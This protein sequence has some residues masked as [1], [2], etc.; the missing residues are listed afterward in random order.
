MSYIIGANGSTTGLQS[1]GNMSFSI[2]SNLKS[3]DVDRDADTFTLSSVSG[4]YEERFD[5]EN[6]T[7]GP[8]AEDIQSATGTFTGV[9]H[10]GAITY[11][12]GNDNVADDIFVN[13]TKDISELTGLYTNRFDDEAYYQIL[14]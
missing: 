1:L 9:Q 13:D 7:G 2:G 12:I 4:T 8:T 6:Y 10:L 3:I 14:I 11:V 5:D